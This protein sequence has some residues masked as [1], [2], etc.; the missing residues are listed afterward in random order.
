[1]TKE[2]ISSSVN[3]TYKSWVKLLQKKYRMKEQLFLVEGAHLVEE[4]VKAGVLKQVILRE[5]TVY[6]CEVPVT[7]LAR[8]LFEKLEQTVTSS[9]IIGVCQ[10]KALPIEN[11]SRLLIVDDVQDPGNLGTLMRS[12]LAFG[13][14][15]MIMSTGTVD[16]YNE[17]V[18]RATQ[19]ALFRLP[20]L[21][22][23]LSDYLPN[24]QAQ[25]VRIYATALHEM[26]V[27]S[28]ELKPE[29]AM[30]FIVGNEGA[31]VKDA[32][33]KQSDGAVVIPMSSEVESLNVGVAGSILMC[34][35]KGI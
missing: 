27:N 30:A 8:A 29:T 9:G 6:E 25:G 3:P 18:I 26:A 21:R 13:Y 34:Q 33:I 24:L 32:L 35:F 11:H 10:M 22:T 5:D 12:A 28:H 17:K 31:G 2:M 20:I 19:G 14:N 1:M 23:D 4:A 7:I 15:G 16:V